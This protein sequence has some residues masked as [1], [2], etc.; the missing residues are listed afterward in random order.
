MGPTASGKTDL[1]CSLVQHFPFEIISIDSAMIYRGLD[2]GSAKPDRSVLVNAPHHLIDILNPTESYSVAQCCQDVIACGEAIQARGHIPLLVGGTM[3]YFR[4][5]QQG[6]AALP[7]ADS[8]VRDILVEQMNEKG[9]GF[10][11]AELARWDPESAHRIHPHDNQRIIRALEVYHVSQ[12]P[13]SQWLR[14]SQSQRRQI[15]YVNMI[16]MPEDR[17]WLHARI[18]QRFLAML[19][20][21]LVEEVTQLLQKW[22]LTS[23]HPAMRCVGYRQVCHYLETH[24][25]YDSLI[26][27]G[28][29]ATRQ[30]A[31]RQLTWLRHWPGGYHFLAENLDNEREMIALVHRIA[32]NEDCFRNSMIDDER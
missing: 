8:K 28:T 3:M 2:I 4:A 27:Q 11:H 23:A 7:G 16:L 14:E 12:K 1:A 13:L 17:S 24:Q 21:G 6:L 25:A 20:A 5:L 15:V 32:D 26:E 22:P 31:K 10:L 29:A 9:L 19:E 18:A 30:L